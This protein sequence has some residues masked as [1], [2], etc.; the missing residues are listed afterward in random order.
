MITVDQVFGS[1]GEANCIAGRLAKQCQTML[2]NSNWHQGPYAL[3][4]NTAVL[5]DLAHLAM[6][7]SL[8]N[9]P[10]TLTCMS[11]ADSKEL[12]M[13]I[14]EG[15]SA[16]TCSEVMMRGRWRRLAFSI[17]ASSRSMVC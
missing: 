13:C 3:H 1:D 10:M 2:M 6:M 17:A 8:H 16:G 9:T 12:S 14:C 4:N 11:R 5:W 15:S 7:P